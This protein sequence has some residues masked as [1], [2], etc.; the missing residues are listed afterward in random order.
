[1]RS[2]CWQCAAGLISKIEGLRQEKHEY[3]VS[4]FE[5]EERLHMNQRIDAQGSSIK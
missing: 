2:S 5:E 4:L 3:V 1:M